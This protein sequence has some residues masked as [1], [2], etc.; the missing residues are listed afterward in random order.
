MKQLEKKGKL[1]NQYKTI[2]ALSVQALLWL[3]AVSNARFQCRSPAYKE[4][5][6][7]LSAYEEFNLILLMRLTYFYVFETVCAWHS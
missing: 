2:Q 4:I 6:K 1:L 5:Y 7:F 3:Y